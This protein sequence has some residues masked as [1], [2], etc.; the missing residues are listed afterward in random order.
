[1]YG[2]NHQNRTQ[3]GNQD[4]RCVWLRSGG[5]CG[6]TLVL[7]VLVAVILTVVAF[8]FIRARVGQRWEN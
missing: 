1:M 8:T 7:P 5:N 6:V 2:A 4:D 3:E